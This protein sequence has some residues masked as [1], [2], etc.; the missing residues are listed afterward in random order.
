MY[1]SLMKFSAIL[2]LMIAT[3]GMACSQIPGY[4]GVVMNDVEEIKSEYYSNYSEEGNITK[5]I[6]M[7]EVFKIEWELLHQGMDP[8]PELPAINFDDRDLILLMLDAKP[9]GGYGI[10]NLKFQ[11]NDEQLIIQY[12]E[13]HPG[14]GCFTTQAITRPYKI[15]SIPKA[16]KEIVFLKG[17]TVI[18]DCGG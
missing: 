1:R 17:E 7:K 12:A 16:D 4:E 10:E 8:V 5:K 13:S 14:S 15:I 11:T 3:M 9:S 6:S 18:N 2:V